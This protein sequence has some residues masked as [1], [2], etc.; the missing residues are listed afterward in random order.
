[1]LVSYNLIVDTSY[2]LTKAEA[3]LAKPCILETI[4]I[5]IPP[6]NGFL[7]MRLPH[8]ATFSPSTIYALPY[9]FKS[10]N[11]YTDTHAPTE[12]HFV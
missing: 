6:L 8:K 3:G 7:D 2:K 10:T 5:I 9:S 1:M 12:L 4:A 11:A